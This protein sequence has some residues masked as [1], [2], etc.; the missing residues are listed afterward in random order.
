MR[1]AIGRIVGCA[2][3]AAA[4]AGCASDPEPR[5]GVAAPSRCLL[6]ESPL[7]LA[8]GTELYVEP[9]NLFRLGDEWMVAGAPSYQW[10][11][12]PGREAVSVTRSAHV[13]AFLGEPAREV[14]SPVPGR[15]GSIISTPLG[16]GRWAAVFDLVDPDSIPARYIPVS[17]WYGEHDG[18]RWTI[19]EPLPITAGTNV[20]LR[21]SS[22]LVAVG[23]RLVWIGLD[24]ELGRLRKLLRYERRDGAWRHELLPDELVEVA[25]LE[26]DATEGLLMLLVGTDVDLPGFQKSIRLYRDGS[27]RELIA[28]VTAEPGAGRTI[29]W[30]SVEVLETG[31]AVSWVVASEEGFRAFARTGIRSGGTADSI[32][33]LD[34][35]A[36]H[37][38]AMTMPDGSLAWVAD[39]LLDRTGRNKELRL[40]RLDGSR[41]VRLATVRNPF[42]GF[43]SARPYGPDEVLLVGPQ[44][45]LVPTETPVRSLILRLSTSC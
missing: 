25:V 6:Q 33:R 35:D 26:Y 21:A 18:T 8:D 27:P 9:Q 43:F 32:V 5:A 10:R 40:L 31:A 16:D 24:A 19:V 36:M 22:N 38:S 45:G 34:D 29:Y 7:V 11:V 1:G 41:V 30:P 13:A 3:A 17:Y 2:T 12:A 23:D 37:L 39:H 28:R 4:L 20:D 14:A 15:I 42:T 44:M